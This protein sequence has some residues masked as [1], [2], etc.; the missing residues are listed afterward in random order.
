MLA[1]GGS[2][3]ASATPAPSP[4]RAGSYYLA[5]GD[6]VAFGYRESTNLPTPD[7]SKANSFVGYPEDVGAALGLHV[8]NASCPGETSSSFI[9]TH[10]TSNGCENSPTGPVGYRTFYPL[11][12][13]YSGTQMSYAIHYLQTH[14][15]THLVTLMIGANDAFLCEE[16]TSDHCASELKATLR[17]ITANVRTILT[18][19]RFQAGY[20]GQ[21]VIVNY[22]SLDYASAT[23]NASSRA[24]N[25]AMDLAGRFYHVTV[26]DGY[27]AFERAAVQS[28]GDTCAAGLLTKLTTGG[29]G[30][31]PSIAGQSLLALAVERAL[32]H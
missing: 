25:S 7:Y 6:S 1:G 24:L 9:A 16:T 4:V 31:H 14:P 26:A 19:L 28:G 20:H 21:I 18:N 32:T 10:V 5:L 27:G 2:A 12:V 22:Y 11:H 23:D 17:Q 13:R 8:I 30:V 15:A 3:S 29:C